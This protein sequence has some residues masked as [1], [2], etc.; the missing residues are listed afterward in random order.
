MACGQAGVPKTSRLG[1][2][3]FAHKPSVDCQLHEGG[4]ESAAHLATKAAVARAAREIGWEAVIEFPA[5]DRSWIA[6]V[7]VTNGERTIAIEAQWA[8]QSLFDFE[9]RQ[10]RYQAA[11]IE[12]LW[13]TTPTNALNASTVPYYELAG[14]AD[15]LQLSMPAL[16]EPRLLALDASIKEILQGTILP[17]AEFV[18]TSTAIRTQMSKCW[19]CARWMSLWNVLELDLESRCGEHTTLK[20]QDPWPLWAPR[21]HEQDLETPIRSAIDNS[22]LPAAATL[23]MKRSEKAETTYVAMNCP[24]CGYVQGD[25]MTKWYWESSEYSIPLGG[26][27]RLPFA[28]KVRTRPHLCRDVG[29]GRCSQELAV[30]A[31]SSSGHAYPPETKY[32]KM[33]AHPEQRDA[34]PPRG[35]RAR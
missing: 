12:C 7:L 5:A 34:L 1:T 32:L 11:G 4:P 19:K 15:D 31:A 9:R 21:R 35:S 24:S 16:P 30:G 29:R 28:E 22:D 33:N 23:K 17:V 3:F 14:D 13:L 26:G 2:Q 18:A 10:A 20:W 8:P 6:D 27:F 25:G